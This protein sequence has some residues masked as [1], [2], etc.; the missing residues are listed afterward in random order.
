M[1]MHLYFSWLKINTK[2]NNDEFKL[3]VTL[4]SP[5]QLVLVWVWERFFKLRPQPNLIRNGE[6]RMAQWNDLKC[7][8]QN[9]RLVLDSSKESFIWRPYTKAV[10]NWDFPKFYMEKDMWVSTSSGLDEEL[11]SFIR[12]LRVSEL[13]GI[14]ADCVQQYLPHRV[15]RQLGIDQDIPDF[16]ARSC[17]SRV[18]AWSCYNIP[19]SDVKCYIPSHLSETDVTT[20]YSLHQIR[21][22]LHFYEF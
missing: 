14:E 4:G 22:W 10:E 20:R 15:A 17:E 8:F 21:L 13:V 1:L 12:C 3:A 5:F 18:D 16:V 6:P 2:H 7:N 11:E 19:L 9:L